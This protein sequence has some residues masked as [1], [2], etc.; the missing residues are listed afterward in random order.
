MLFVLKAMFNFQYFTIFGLT[1]FYDGFPN[2]YIQK[3]TANVIKYNSVIRC[4]YFFKMFFYNGFIE[5]CHVTGKSNQMVIFHT[6]G[7]DMFAVIGFENKY[8]TDNEANG[9]TNK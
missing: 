2:I 1:K 4:L 9:N 7:N 5:E 8:D 3:G 6:Y